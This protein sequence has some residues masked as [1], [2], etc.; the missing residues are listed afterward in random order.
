MVIRNLEK[1]GE[2]VETNACRNTLD[3][4]IITLKFD[5]SKYLFLIHTLLAS[6]VDWILNHFKLLDFTFTILLR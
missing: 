5:C 6:E 1:D 4:L 2:N 3:F